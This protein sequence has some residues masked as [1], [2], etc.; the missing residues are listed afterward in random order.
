LKSLQNELTVTVL[1]HLVKSLNGTLEKAGWHSDIPIAHSLKQLTA[2]LMMS[3][4]RM[5]PFGILVCIAIILGTLV[6]V[7]MT[8]Y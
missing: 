5:Q 6:L 3:N 4:N 2:D 7:A 1:V 8:V